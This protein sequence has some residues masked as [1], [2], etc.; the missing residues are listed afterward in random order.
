MSNYATVSAKQ[1]SWGQCKPIWSKYLWPGRKII[2]T[3]SSM[4]DAE[5]GIDM[6]IYERYQPYFFGV[7]IG[8]KLVGVNSGHQ[9]SATDFRSRGLYVLEDYRGLSI[10]KLVLQATLD[11]GRS[12]N[13]ERC[14][15]M[16]RESA[17]SAYERVGFERKSE[18]F[19][20][21]TSESNCY[22]EVLL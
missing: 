17:L 18:W 8:Q 7:Y 16:P 5:G 12:L 21:E 15:T 6:K 13:C 19:K 2:Q 11:K 22:A 14:W 1:I 4:T 3:M 20:T 9:T 10:S